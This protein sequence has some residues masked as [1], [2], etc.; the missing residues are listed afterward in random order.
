MLVVQA[1]HFM[2]AKKQMRSEKEGPEYRYLLK[3]H[4]Q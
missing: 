1:P 4:A 3:G 2:M